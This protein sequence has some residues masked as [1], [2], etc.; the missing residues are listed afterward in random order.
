MDALTKFLNSIAYKFPKGYPDMNNEQDILLLETELQRMGVN[1]SE[2]KEEPK[3]DYKKQLKDLIDSSNISDETLQ[4]LIKNLAGSSSRS[5]IN[6]YLNQKGFTSEKFKTGD[7]AINYILD[8]LTSTETKEFIEYIQNPKKFPDDKI[9]GNLSQITGLSNQLISD[10]INIEPGFDSSGSAI[11]KAEIFLALIFSNINNRSGGGDLNF[12][13][14]NLEVKG[15]GGRL[16]QQGGRGSDANYVEFLAEKFL[17]DDLAQEFISNPEN[18]YINY[19]LKNIYD[20]AIKNGNKS[21]DV[22]EYLQRLLNQVYFNK[23]IAKEYFNSPD[24]FKDLAKI[25]KNLLKL[26]IKSYAKKINTQDFLFINPKTNDY[27]LID[28]DKVEDVVD[29]GYVD[30]IVKDLTKGYQWNNPFPQIVIR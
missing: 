27:A 13:G 20:L 1:L 11:G 2:V 28:I 29:K 12:D 7:S 23:D 19:A 26:N 9:K 24:D 14:K 30:T 6:T 3:I 5:E 22:I 18:A 21:Q 8:K 10:L 15:M 17:P 4:K 25:K 16:G